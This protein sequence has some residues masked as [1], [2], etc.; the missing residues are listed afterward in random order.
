MPDMTLL[1]ST[2]VYFSGINRALASIEI[3]IAKLAAVARGFANEWLSPER[4]L[5]LAAL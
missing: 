4:V 5:Q 1:M 3:L 2:H